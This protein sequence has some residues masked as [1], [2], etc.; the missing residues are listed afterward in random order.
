ML[1]VAHGKSTTLL[2]QSLILNTAI[3]RGRKS[4]NQELE[5]AI[6][7]NVTSEFQAYARFKFRHVH[8]WAFKLLKSQTKRTEGKKDQF[9]QQKMITLTN[10]NRFN[11]FS[12]LVFYHFQVSAP[13]SMHKQRHNFYSF[14]LL[15][16]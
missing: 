9:N 13:R 11:P 7:A 4:V 16:T 15:H 14:P 2:P 3:S 8:G 10:P 1:D 12:V 6:L 5:F